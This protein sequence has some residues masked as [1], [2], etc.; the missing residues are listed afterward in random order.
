MEWIYK[1]RDQ[2]TRESARHSTKFER[3]LAASGK[4]VCQHRAAG[5]GRRCS[6]VIEFAA[7][8]SQRSGPKMTPAK[9]TLG[10]VLAVVMVNCVLSL[11]SER[12]ALTRNKAVH[13]DIRGLSE[14]SSPMFSV[15]PWWSF[16]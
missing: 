9:I 1:K 13:P 2:T 8:C 6:P 7:D 4:T 5:K 15:P 12:C 14:K 16:S 10:L 3:G 11:N